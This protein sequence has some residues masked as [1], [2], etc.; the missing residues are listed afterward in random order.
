MSRKT[1]PHEPLHS[2]KTN[3]PREFKSAHSQ[4][5]E[6]KTQVAPLFHLHATEGQQRNGGLS[7]NNIFYVFTKPGSLKILLC[8]EPK[9]RC[10]ERRREGKWGSKR[11]R[12]LNCSPGS[13]T[14]GLSSS[15]FQNI[16][17]TKTI[18]AS[19]VTVCAW[20]VSFSSNIHTV[21]P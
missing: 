18:A 4:A 10:M 6:P 12:V 8:C 11:E 21:Q 7:I 14:K 9:V 19:C 20:F 16:R 17:R 13:K 5:P 15:E 2:L 3:R 1:F